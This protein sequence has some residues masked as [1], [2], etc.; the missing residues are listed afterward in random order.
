MVDVVRSSIDDSDPIFA[1]DSSPTKF[2]RAFS[3]LN[4]FEFLFQPHFRFNFTAATAQYRFIILACYFCVS[5]E[6]SNS[7]KL[8]QKCDQ[9]DCALDPNHLNSAIIIT[10]ITLLSAAQNKYK[11]NGWVECYCGTTRLCGGK[12]KVS[13]AWSREIKTPLL[14]P[15]RYSTF[16]LVLYKNTNWEIRIGL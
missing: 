11:L 8:S 10:W 7:S 6:F 5:L 1:L 16:G 2:D 4:C 9:L 12:P 13:P 3:R 14:I 15:N